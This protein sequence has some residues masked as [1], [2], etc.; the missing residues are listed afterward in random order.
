MLSAGS[1]LFFIFLHGLNEGGTRL[2]QNSDS[3]LISDVGVGREKVQGEV[4]ERKESGV[5]AVQ[6]MR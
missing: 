1:S 6:M 3:V 5:D 2:E 4:E